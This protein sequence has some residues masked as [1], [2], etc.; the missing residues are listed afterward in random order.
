MLAKVV[1]RRADRAPR[2]HSL[3]AAIARGAGR[4]HSLWILAEP[5][6]LL[7]H[8]SDAFDVFLIMSQHSVNP[9]MD[10]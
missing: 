1:R 3:R 10:G 4:S 8:L 6:A 5:A 9:T 2:A 7:E